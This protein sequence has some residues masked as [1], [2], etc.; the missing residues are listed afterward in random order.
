MK[1]NHHRWKERETK[2]HKLFHSTNCLFGG[3]SAFYTKEIQ[4]RFHAQQ[5]VLKVI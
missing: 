4:A 3:V 5:Q 1:L 2:G